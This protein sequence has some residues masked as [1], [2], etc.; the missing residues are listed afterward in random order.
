MFLLHTL[1][2]R[3]EQSALLE[4]I[5]IISRLH[6]SYNVKE[7]RPARRPGAVAGSVFIRQEERV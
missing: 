3:A 6:N 5:G 2:L 4:H 7:K 1:L